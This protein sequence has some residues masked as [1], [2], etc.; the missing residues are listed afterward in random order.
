MCEFSVE[1]FLKKCISCVSKQ[2]NIPSTY[3]NMTAFLI[4]ASNGSEECIFIKQVRVT[5]KKIQSRKKWMR[6]NYG[7]LH[8][9][10]HVNEKSYEMSSVPYVYCCNE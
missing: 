2:S 1:R 6:N 4:Y 3:G 10:T 7:F 5:R 8:A 9:L